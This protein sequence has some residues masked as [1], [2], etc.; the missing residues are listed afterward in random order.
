MGTQLARTDANPNQLDIVG[1]HHLKEI[2]EQKL[3][4]TRAIQEACNVLFAPTELDTIPPMFQPVVSLVIIDAKPENKQVYTIAKDTLGLSKSAIYK[5]LRTAGLNWTRPQKL[6]PIHDI[7]NYAYVATVYGMLP[8]GKPFRGEDTA[9]WN[10]EK[11]LEANRLNAQKKLENARKYN[12]SGD[13]KT[14]ADPDAWALKRTLEE[15]EFADERTATRA[16]LRAARG[17]LGLKTSYSPEE[18]Q[19]P[20]LVASSVPAFDMNDADT[21]RMVTQAALGAMYGLYPPPQPQS[22]MPGQPS[23]G[24]M[25]GYLP[26]PEP[27]DASSEIDA[28]YT[29]YDPIGDEAQSPSEP[30]EPADINLAIREVAAR[31]GAEAF[32]AICQRHTGKTKLAGASDDVKRDVYFEAEALWRANNG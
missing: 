11:R 9:S 10:Y 24:D 7:N 30:S 18:L 23:S 1:G 13:L 25:A 15:R 20:F 19:K 2:T 28:D 16:I 32:S 29:Q 27:V 12:Y 21:K 17:A 8:N 6:T 14:Y 31:I 5:I 26:S 4:K 3:W 22:A